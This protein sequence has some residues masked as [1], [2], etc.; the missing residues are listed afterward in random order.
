MERILFKLFERQPNWT[1]RQLVQ[2]TDQPEQFLKDLLK[3]LCVYNGKGANQ[4][5]YELK[6]EYRKFSGDPG[7]STE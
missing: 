7:T 3:D 2:D 6:P 5:T 4:G 1:L